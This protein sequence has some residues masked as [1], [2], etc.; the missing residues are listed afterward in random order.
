MKNIILLISAIS[1]IIL[2]AAQ[3]PA[4]PD[5]KNNGDQ[6][7]FSQNSWSEV[8]DLAK[9]ENKPV[10]LDIS[11]SWCGYCKRMKAN[12][13]T[14]TDVSVFYNSNYIN[15]SV[16]GEKGEGIELAKKYGVTGYPT[17]VFLKPDGSVA[18]QT[19]GFYNSEKFLEIGKNA[20]NK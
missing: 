2:I 19:S 4:D 13:F 10:F 1:M 7:K 16:D 18:F 6:I 12:V 8:L 11:A 5:I 20:F 14:N 9:K 17:F 15:V 3:K